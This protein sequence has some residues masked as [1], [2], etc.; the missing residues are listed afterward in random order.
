MYVGAFRIRHRRSLRP[1]DQGPTLSLT[2]YKS[3]LPFL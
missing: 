3:G 1:G 2:F